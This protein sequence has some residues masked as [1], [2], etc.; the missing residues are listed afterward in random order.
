MPR[1]RESIVIRSEQKKKTQ[2]DP[3]IQCQGLFFL[4]Y[5]FFWVFDAKNASKTPKNRTFNVRVKNT[6]FRYNLICE[7][8]HF[9]VKNA[10]PDMH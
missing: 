9:T 6:P 10:K 5:W 3:D 7:V 8:A 2:K 4:S 1:W